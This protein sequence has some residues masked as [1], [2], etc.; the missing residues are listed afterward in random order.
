MS[1]PVGSAPWQA[2]PHPMR[3]AS[4]LNGPVEVDTRHR[5]R[6]T[7]QRTEQPDLDA[8]ANTILPM[9]LAS[10]LNSPEESNTSQRRTGTSTRV[11]QPDL[12]AEDGVA[13]PCGT[14][15]SGS[16]PD[17]PAPSPTSQQRVRHRRCRLHTKKYDPEQAYWIW[18]HRIDL[19]EEWDEV[20]EKYSVQFGEPRGKSGIQTKYYRVLNEHRVEAV[21]LQRKGRKKKRRA[22]GNTFGVVQRTTE[23]FA[24][25]R[26]ADQRKP[27]LP[28][29]ASPKG[30]G[31]SLCAICAS[32]PARREVRLLSAD[33]F[34]IR[35]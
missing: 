4:I 9:R 31:I 17:T 21:R 13:T 27:P 14:D 23:R 8:E 19:G 26:P 35:V 32:A 11:E 6:G 3:L 18:Y 22:P 12:V 5:E 1:S 15:N 30:C 25:M 28:C 7:D 10:I 29:F 24:W 34:P 16:P 33:E 20:I 2:S